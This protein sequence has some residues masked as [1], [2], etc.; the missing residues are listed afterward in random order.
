MSGATVYC[1]NFD[2]YGQTTKNN[3]KTW[4]QLDKIKEFKSF[5]KKDILNEK[6]VS[7]AMR[8]GEKKKYAVIWYVNLFYT[9]ENDGPINEEMVLNFRQLMGGTK[10]DGETQVLVR[11]EGKPEQVIQNIG[12]YQK[13][14]L[15]YNKKSYQFKD[16]NYY[17]F[18]LK[19]DQKKHDKL[20]P[21]AWYDY[22][23]RLNLFR[24][25]KIATEQKTKLEKI[26]DLLKDRTEKLNK[27]IG[28]FVR[29]AEKIKDKQIKNGDE[30]KKQI[31]LKKQKVQLAYNELKNENNLKNTK[32][33]DVESRLEEAENIIEVS[34]EERKIIEKQL[35]TALKEHEENLTKLKEED[36]TSYLNLEDG[37]FDSDMYYYLNEIS[38]NDD[39][40]FNYNMEELDNLTV[41]DDLDIELINPEE[42]FVKENENGNINQGATIGYNYK[43]KI[44]GDTSQTKK[45]DLLYAIDKDDAFFFE[46]KRPRDMGTY[47]FVPYFNG[48][49]NISTLKVSKFAPLKL[50]E[51]KNFTDEMFFFEDLLKVKPGV[52]NKIEILDGTL[53]KYNKYREYRSFVFSD[54]KQDRLSDENE[55]FNI[56]NYLNKDPAEIKSTADD[57]PL[58]YKECFIIPLITK[59]PNSQ[60]ILENN[61]ST[62]IGPPSGSNIM[63]FIDLENTCNT[64]TEIDSCIFPCE[65]SNDEC[66]ARMQDDLFTGRD[67]K[68]K[69]ELL[70]TV[71]RFIEKNFPNDDKKVVDDRMTKLV[72]LI[73]KFYLPKK[74]EENP[75]EI[76]NLLWKEYMKVQEERSWKS[77]YN[78]LYVVLG[79]GAAT[80][81]ISYSLYESAIRSP[82]QNPQCELS[83]ISAK[84]F[85]LGKLGYTLHNTWHGEINEWKYYGGVDPCRGQAYKKY[86]ISP[87]RVTKGFY[88]TFDTSPIE[89]E[90]NK[91]FGI[92]LDPIPYKRFELIQ[93]DKNVEK[94]IVKQLHGVIVNGNNM[95]DPEKNL[96]NAIINNKYNT[97]WWKDSYPKVYKSEENDKFEY[98]ASKIFVPPSSD[99]IINYTFGRNNTQESWRLSLEEIYK[100]LE[101]ANEEDSNGIFWKNAELVPEKAF[102]LFTN[103][104]NKDE[105]LNMTKD[106]FVEKPESSFFERFYPLSNPFNSLN[107]QNF[108]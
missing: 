77:F 53:E 82:L 14:G 41:E 27:R 18:S 93:K 40:T 74:K 102:G 2:P 68:K 51:I 49:Y 24:L 55:I 97:V 9:N 34:D 64:I 26:S 5:L 48:L 58:I 91:K 35:E 57:Y 84:N 94:K 7:D 87:F 92:Y 28:E 17:E 45:D 80:S 19:Y 32:L 105:N 8:D 52:N 30:L 11:I 70:S 73:G 108:A 20:E 22:S 43:F 6:K 104:L 99:P 81:S 78:Y 12:E 50:E 101:R 72:N 69:G 96:N 59:Y 38:Q 86:E 21:N 46:F 47:L 29:L 83:E 89:G 95:K 3:F 106:D 10:I 100:V 79:V 13:M 37:F 33:N 42:V 63:E 107:N 56:E 85:Q 103:Y 88:L 90:L 76:I 60:N 39:D 36:I 65:W 54:V 31:E 1:I 75:R 15:F 61:I 25:R 16:K 67:F 44:K 62:F 66:N 23:E 71:K 4:F 98:K